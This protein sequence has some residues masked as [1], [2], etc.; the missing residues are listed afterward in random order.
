LPTLGLEIERTRIGRCLNWMVAG[1]SLERMA[2]HAENVAKEV[3][4]LCEAQDIRHT[5]KLPG[6]T[7]PG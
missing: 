2:D 5:G 7:A 6:A 4:Y 1:K 3:V